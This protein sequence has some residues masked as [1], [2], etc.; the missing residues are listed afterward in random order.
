[1]SRKLIGAYFIVVGLGMIALWSMLLLT[2]QA[3]EIVTAPWSIAMH[4]ATEFLTGAM[5]VVS[6][7]GLLARWRLARTFALIAGGMLIYTVIQS[8]GYY[9]NL[10]QAPMVAMF[11]VTGTLALVAVVALARQQQ[12]APS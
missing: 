5:L 1:M 6:G 10:G 2:H 11:G 12:P 8:P 7:V 4:L 9:L 3:P